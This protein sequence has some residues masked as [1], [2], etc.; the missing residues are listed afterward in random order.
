MRDECIHNLDADALELFAKKGCGGSPN[1]VQAGQANAVKVR[2]ILQLTR[3]FAGPEFERMRILD[4]GCAEGVYAIE[5]ALRG[6]DV[7]A[8]DARTERMNPGAACAGRHGIKGVRFLQEDVRRVTKQ[9]FGQFNVVYVLGILYHF[10]APDVFQ[11]IENIYELCCGM[12]VIDTFVT[13][14][15]ETSVEW[16]GLVFQGR[17]LRE[18]ADND[19]SELRRSRLLA[20]IDNTF[21]FRFTRESLIHALQ[22]AGFTSVLECQVPFEPGKREDRTTLVAVKGAPVLLS[23]YPWIN[24]QSEPE[25]E[26]ALR[27]GPQ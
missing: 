4:L 18:H 2:R 16:R 27:H 14:E 17:R 10:D 5:A 26:R 9:S 3:D 19:S 7:T 8:V 22:V 21:S 13:L 6:A 11:V 1:V 12:V 25:I 15:A 20:S 24:G 23:T